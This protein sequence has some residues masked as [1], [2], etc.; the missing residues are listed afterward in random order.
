MEE[1]YFKSSTFTRF[2]NQNLRTS[3]LGNTKSRQKESN[4]HQVEETTSGKPNI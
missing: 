4:Y 1:M 3:S 2:E